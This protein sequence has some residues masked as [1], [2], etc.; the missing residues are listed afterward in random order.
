MSSSRAKGLNTNLISPSDYI[1]YNSDADS[2]E[3]PHLYTYREADE[4]IGR[5]I[6]TI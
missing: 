3:I 4:S 6:V 2:Q 5:K 1:A